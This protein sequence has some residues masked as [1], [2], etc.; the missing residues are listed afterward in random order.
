MSHKCGIHLKC[1]VSFEWHRLPGNL[2]GFRVE[3]Q[4]ASGDG[5]DGADTN[6]PSP[7]W[8]TGHSLSHNT[9]HTTHTT[10]TTHTHSW[11]K[12]ELTKLS[13]PAC[14]C[15]DC[16]FT[17]VWTI[18]GELVDSTLRSQILRNTGSGFLQHGSRLVLIL[19]KT[20]SQSALQ[21]GG[22][23]KKNVNAKKYQLPLQGWIKLYWI[24]MNI[25]ST[26]SLSSSWVNLSFK[27]YWWWYGEDK[28]F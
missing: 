23:W 2:S 22:R 12:A 1:R 21:K 17:T 19:R 18:G 24:E 13:L 9:K 14:C 27:Y 5:P 8:P 15:W 4:E 28:Y 16:F 6:P 7:C 25:T 10:H 26:C 20:G 11:I 3:A